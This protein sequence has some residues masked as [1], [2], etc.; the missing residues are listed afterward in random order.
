[1]R[2]H[3]LRRQHASAGITVGVTGAG[4]WRA[5]CPP[6]AFTSQLRS[7]IRRPNSDAPLTTR[8]LADRFTATYSSPSQPLQGIISHGTKNQEPRTKNQEPRTKNQEPGSR[9]TWISESSMKKV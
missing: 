3:S 4:Y 1:M 6:G 7:D 5:D 9:S 8:A 2:L